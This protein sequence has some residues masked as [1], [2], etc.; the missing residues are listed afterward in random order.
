MTDYK[1]RKTKKFAE[2]LKIWLPHLREARE[3]CEADINIWYF[4]NPLAIFMSMLG[5]ILVTCTFKNELG[6]IIVAMVLFHVAMFIMVMSANHISENRINV[7]YN[8]KN[9]EII[10]E[11]YKKELAAAAFVITDDRFE[12]MRKRVIVGFKMA[13]KYHP[14][15]LFHL[16]DVTFKPL[17][18]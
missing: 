2:N 1:T 6:T 17:Q 4:I 8:L 3:Q 11:S 18:V 14:C 15:K 16:I 13:E 12:V 10:L 9:D 5:N 7:I